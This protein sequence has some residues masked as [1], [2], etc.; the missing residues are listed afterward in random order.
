MY[1]V[2]NS[3]LLY[4]GIGWILWKENEE[5]P[6]ELIYKVNYLGEWM[7]TY[8]LNFSRGSGCII[9]QYYNFL[10]LG[11]QG[12]REIMTNCLSNARYL[13]S[14]LEK[15]APFTISNR[16]EKLPIVI[17]SLNDSNFTAIEISKR[18]REKGWI[19]SADTL[20][21]DA[22]EVAVLRVVV[23]ENFSFEQTCYFIKSKKYAGN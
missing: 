7:P 13:S 4:P 2:I 20:P 10:R 14:R 19:V 1:R 5:F 15:L 3:G 23:R 18:L 12:Y 21:K 9:S 17:L 11:R 16:G 8:T 22:D 6:E